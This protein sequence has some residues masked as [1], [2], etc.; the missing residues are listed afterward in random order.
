[1]EKLTYYQIC[2][3]I[4]QGREDEIPSEYNIVWTTPKPQ[5]L[6]D[7][8]IPG[9]RITVNGN[10]FPSPTKAYVS[11]EYKVI[12]PIHIIED[13]FL[14]FGTVFL[15]TNFSL[16]K[17]KFEYEHQYDISSWMNAKFI[18]SVKQ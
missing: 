9:E 11:G 16:S 8:E 13:E 6:F 10:D 4:G 17:L 15:H 1:M 5:K 12:I 2:N 3:L 18:C 14:D 7:V